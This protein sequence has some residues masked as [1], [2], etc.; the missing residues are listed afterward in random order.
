MK[1]MIGIMSLLLLNSLQAQF[2]VNIETSAAFA[3]KEVY[4]YTLNGSK[5][6]LSSKELRKGNSWQIK[7]EKPYSGMLKLYFPEANISVNFISENKDVKLKF[8][9]EKNKISDIQYL[10]DANFTMNNMQDVQQKKEYI[11]PALQ[12]IKGYYKG[13]TGFANALNDEII[14][15][16][17]TTED[18]EKYPFISFYNTNYTKYLESNPSKKNITHDDIINFFVKADDKLESSSLMRPILLSY[19][20]LGSKTEVSA[21]V[22]KLLKG[23]NTETIRGQT[24]LSEL[25]EIFDTY[26]M[27]E[28]KDKYLAEAK[29]LKCTI[30]ERLSGVL[31]I[32]KNTEIG[33]LFP[34]QIFIKPV[35]T[36]AKSIYDVKADKKVI[37]FWSSTCSHCE[38]EL[39]K[40]LE[41]YNTMKAQKIEIIGLSLDTEKESYENKVK[42]LPWIN[43]TEL[44]GWN[45]SFTEKYNV[46]A[47]PSYFVLDA[48]NKIIAKPDHAS[49]L[50]F[51]LKL[52]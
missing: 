37:I 11:L 28:L 12:Q 1:K 9:A 22:D 19:L 7:V 42:N 24:V 16:S 45:S 15:L 46:R 52:N 10:D 43:D 17:N 14:R 23:V 32:N 26:D 5:D 44:K 50:I 27:K 38:A 8:D 49:D 34:N 20:N 18:F 33:A 13:N 25:I 35:N 40:L 30:H 47:T 36:S 31:E 2:K 6:I 21:D 4:L 41:K 39:P 29:N 48:G 51:Y 3:P